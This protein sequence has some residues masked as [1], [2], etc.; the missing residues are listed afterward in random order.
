MDEPDASAVGPPDDLS[1]DPGTTVSLVPS[2]RRDAFDAFYHQC[3]P[4]LVRALSLSLGDDELGRDAAAEGLT[5]ALQRWRKVSGYDNPAGWAYR[6]GLNWARSRRRKLARELPTTSPD[7]AGRV[8]PERDPAIV[9]ALR[10]LS[11]DH[12]AVV[13]CRYY[14]DWS[15]ANIAEALGIAPGTVKSRLSR[16]LARLADLLEDHDA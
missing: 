8:Q 12:R 3:H 14:L 7:D 5:R 2:S 10:T 4:S 11:V 9:D 6:V 1:V 13:V 15:E 16:A